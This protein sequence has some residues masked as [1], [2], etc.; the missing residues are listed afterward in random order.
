MTPSLPALAGFSRRIDRWIDPERRPSSGADLRRARIVV[1]EGWLAIASYA[2]LTTTLVLGAAPALPLAQVALSFAATLAALAL[3]R[4]GGRIEPAA[5]ILTLGLALTPVFQASVDLGIRDPALA[6]VMLAPLAGAMTSGARLA[7][8]GAGV[9]IVGTCVLF[10]LDSAGLAPSP[11]ST[12]ADAAAYAVVMV[13][14]GSALTAVTGVLYVQQTRQ[15]IDQVEG[16]STRLDAALRASEQRYRSLFDHLPVGMYRTAADGRIL[17]ANP[18]LARLIGAAGPESARAFN[19]ADLYADPADRDRFRETILRDGA[20]RGFEVEW[21]RP[22]GGARHV[23]LDARV[24]LDADGRPLFYE[25]AVED[26]T[27]EREARHALHRSEARFRA[28]VQRSSDVVVVADRAD[29]L[30]YVSPTVEALLGH[31]PDGVLGEPLAALVHPDDL[32]VI[33]AF[34]AEARAGASAPGVELRLRHADGHDVFVDGAATVLYDD[35]AV[36]GLVLNLRDVT[37]RKRAQAVLVRAKHQAEEVAALKSTFIANMS[38]E[39]R[40]PLTA[41]LGFADVLGEEVEDPVQSEFVDLIAKSGRR[42]MDTLNSVLDLARIDAGAD[43]ARDPLDAGALADEVATMFG[44]AAGERGLTIR[45][46]VAPGDHRVVAD[47]AALVRV[48]HNLVGNAIKFTDEGSVTVAVRSVSGEGGRRV[49]LTVSDTGIG[50]DPAFLPRM[51]GEFEQES[52]GSGRRYEGAGLG[53]ALSHQLVEQMEGTITVESEK[54]VGTTFSVSFPSADAAA[55]ADGRPLVLVVDDNEQARR[56]AVHMLS[57]AFRIATA[58]DGASALAALEAERPD[59]AVLD[60]HLGLSISGEDVM[61]QLRASNAFA[62]LPMVAVTAYGLPGDRERFLAAGFDAYLQKPYSRSD[63]H[64]TVRHAL[65]LRGVLDEEPEAAEPEAAEPEAAEVRR[66]AEPEAASEPEGP[67]SRRP[68]PTSPT[69]PRP[70]PP[71][72]SRPRPRP[73][74]RGRLMKAR[75]PLRRPLSPRERDRVRGPRVPDGRHAQSRRPP[76]PLKRWRGDP[77]PTTKRFLSPPSRRS[78]AG[79]SRA[80]RSR[81]GRSRAGRSRPIPPRPIPS[82]GRGR[83]GRRRLRLAP[84]R[85]ARAR[86]GA[87]ERRA[88]ERRQ[89]RVGGTARASPGA[90]APPPV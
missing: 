52:S 65:R 43:L 16:E 54:G 22:D 69:S 86:R 20:V 21:R 3:V 49:V 1:V 32:G 17:L 33:D 80:G 15:R 36:A 53:L 31:A 55:D 9:G 5:W 8:V 27:A 63:L 48:L 2:A 77:I 68:S 89:R 25:G 59:L 56:V 79:R 73:N 35:P 14:V 10:G 11:F 85:P 81:A 44:P 76:S 72:P 28:L 84:E 66:A 4:W 88:R 83:A 50:V 7:L 38:H 18:A 19:A 45:A 26:V 61:R 6:F 67:S 82:Q 29:R 24:A 39:I 41:I 46:E 70:K 23:R 47:E 75:R 34:L 62:A 12:A 71:C 60:I 90:T 42:L 78:R 40:T 51:F 58:D 13:V 87:A 37:E 64:A 30:T 57:D 74:R